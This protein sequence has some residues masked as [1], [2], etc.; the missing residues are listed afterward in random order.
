MNW[1]KMVLSKYAEFSGR[2]RRS[3]YWYFMLFNVI[4]SMVLALVD[5]AVGSF[6]ILG[7][8]YSLF[9][10]IPSLALTVRRLHDTGRS[11]WWMLI[12][13]IPFIGWIV[14]LV[15]TV[16]DSQYGDN[17]YGPN[18]KTNYEFGM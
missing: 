8:L 18:P 3:E 10:F 14:L 12:S 16:S 5:M 4:I 15:F 13:L 9:I 2:S 17:Q 11:G 1:Y 7:G 6:G